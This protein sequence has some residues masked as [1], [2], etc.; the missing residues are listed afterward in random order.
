MSNS[1][2]EPARYVTLP[3]GFVYDRLAAVGHVMQPVHTRG[4]VSSRG[5][6]EGT[7][8]FAP[9]P[10]PPGVT[11]SF[12]TDG[13]VNA[14]HAALADHTAGYVMQ[15]RRHGQPIASAQRNWAKEPTDGSLAWGQDVRMHI[16]SCSKLITA[17]SMTRTLAAHN[18]PASTKIINYLPGYWVKGPNIDKITFAQLLTHT[19]GFRVDGSDMSYPTMKALIERGVSAAEHGVPSYQNTNFSLCRILLPIMNRTIVASATFPSFIE[20]QLWDHV[21]IS[22]YAAYV[23]QHI[24]RP[25]GVTGPTLTHPEPD[26]LAYAFAPAAGWNSGDLSTESGGAGWHMS[27]NELLDVMS[28]FRRQGTILS[29]TAAQTMLDCGFG[30]D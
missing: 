8:S 5:P 15:L 2:R 19:S 23:E 20:D 24:F 17:M 28:C 16:A 14:L 3:S 26:A 9:R 12:N 13:F 25:A 11:L 29:P 6:E 22:A 1:P 18:L 7:K 27:V 30:I 10:H 4:I 21:T